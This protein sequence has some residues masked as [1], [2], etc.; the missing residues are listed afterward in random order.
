[1]PP[2]MGWPEGQP[3]DV[4]QGAW[5]QDG[6]HPPLNAAKGGCMFRSVIRHCP[7]PVCFMTR[8][9][10]A[11][12]L[13]L[14]WNLSATLAADDGLFP[15]ELVEF[16]AA[17]D[18]PVFQA[19]GPGH[20]DVRIRERGWILR[21]D[22]RYHMWFTGYDGTREGIKQLGYAWSKDGREWTRLAANPLQRGHWIED[23]MVVRHAG[24]LYMFAEG[25]GD[26]AQLLSSKDGVQ[27]KRL[28]ALDVRQRNGSPI[29]AGPYGTPTAWVEDGKWY[30]F[31][32][33][34]DLGIWL[35]SSTDMRVWTHVQ[36]HPVL[37][38]GPHAYDRDLVALNQIVRHKGRY[39]A[40]YHGAARAQPKTL[41]TTNVAVSEDLRSWTKYDRNPLFPTRTNKS[42]G[43][44][45][46]DG[47]R[48]RLYTMHDQVHLHLPR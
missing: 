42:S 9:R 27:W 17:R 13:V 7:Q 4:E 5:R 37:S 20:W 39:Y 12:M 32:E 15:R 43:I 47:G 28:G 41:W 35:A 22:D 25:R 6:C 44:L 1:M 34:R 8:N 21:D 48:F 18:N 3:W 36:D 30:L 23:M 33:R 2:C 14:C 19:A 26:Q 45:V 31:Y 40:Y 10:I 46:P 38:P 29:E 24:T 16:R 11:L